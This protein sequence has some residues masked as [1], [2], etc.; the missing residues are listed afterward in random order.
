MGQAVDE[1]K[2][3]LELTRTEIAGHLDTVERRI[4]AELDW[5]ARLRRDGPQIAA[6]LG[7]VAV[8]ATA[9]VVL[10]HRLGRRKGT[11]DQTARADDLG[12]VSLRDLAVEIRELRAEV[13]RLREGKG[14][15]GGKDGTPLWARLALGAVG[16][17]ASAG[18]RA[19]AKRLADQQSPEHRGGPPG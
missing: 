11:R 9:A 19:A 1:A 13:E 18:G 16:T 3:Q 12:R 4:R 7:G 6:V 5:K 14:G 15:K 2:R 8:V 10:R 17:A